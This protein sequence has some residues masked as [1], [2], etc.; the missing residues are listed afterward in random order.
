MCA[1]NLS[2]SIFV[3]HLIILFFP[4]RKN[5]NLSL[6]RILPLGKNEQKQ[7]IRFFFGRIN[8]F[9]EKRL[10][11]IQETSWLIFIPLSLFVLP[12]VSHSRGILARE[13]DGKNFQTSFNI[14]QQIS[15]PKQRQQFGDLAQ[16]RKYFSTI[17]RH[18]FR[19]QL[20]VN[21]R[22]CEYIETAEK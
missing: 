2:K 18:C 22:L 17:F 3:E 12:W 4:S 20:A 8:S 10:N 13:I 11:R 19:F 7:A 16:K 9:Y 15:V 6:D 21:A 14:F 5:F 1:F